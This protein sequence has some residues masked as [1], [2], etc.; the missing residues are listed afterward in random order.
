MI[1]PANYNLYTSNGDRL[2][3]IKPATKIMPGG[4]MRSTGVFGLNEGKVDLGDIVFDDK[5]NEWE[6]SCMGDLTHKQAEEIASFIK[7]YHEP[8]PEDRMMDE[9]MAV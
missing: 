3:I 4:N 1:K 7:N 2:I 5:M 6:Y 9:G 8:D